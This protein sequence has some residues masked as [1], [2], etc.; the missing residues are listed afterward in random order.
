M[1]GLEVTDRGQPEAGEEE[2]ETFLER[3]LIPESEHDTVPR[4]TSEAPTK[5]YKHLNRNKHK[6]KLSKKYFNVGQSKT[7]EFSNELV[8]RYITG[9]EETVTV[10]SE[11]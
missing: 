1:G 6:V 11:E 10:R 9:T 4:V 8:Q 3:V 7:F 2:Q 5:R